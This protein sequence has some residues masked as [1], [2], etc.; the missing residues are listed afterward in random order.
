MISFQTQK[1]DVQLSTR[2]VFCRPSKIE[3]DDCFDDDSSLEDLCLTPTR[4]ASSKQHIILE[5][6][7]T[8]SNSSKQ[9]SNKSDQFPNS[10]Q[11]ALAILK[12][13]L[14]FP[15]KKKIKAKSILFSIEDE[16]S[17]QE[18]T[19]PQVYMHTFERVH[20]SIKKMSIDKKVNKGRRFFIS[21]Y[22]LKSAVRKLKA[23]QTRSSTS[24]IIREMKVSSYLI[25]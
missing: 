7:S 23:N 6:S 21:K 17:D 24:K 19:D 10:E 3:V 14:M 15:D 13:R 4:K 9:M 11:L 8:D 18:Y 12:M 25:K 5:G 1:L 22:K 16:S 20:K 2:A